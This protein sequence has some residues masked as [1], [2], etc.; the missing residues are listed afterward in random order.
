MFAVLG[1]FAVPVALNLERG[2]PALIRGLLV[3]LVIAVAVVG[4]T[5]TRGVER[6]GRAGMP[7][8]VIEKGRTNCPPGDSSFIRDARPDVGLMLLATA[9]AYA[10]AHLLGRRRSRRTIEL[11][12]GPR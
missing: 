2:G 1:L 5:A 10:A 6:G 11:T 12:D 7:G 9:G 3:G 4:Y 8:C